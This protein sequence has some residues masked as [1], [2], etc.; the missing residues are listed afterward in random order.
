MVYQRGRSAVLKVFQGAKFVGNSVELRRLRGVVGQSG[1][2]R[3]GSGCGAGWK[4]KRVEKGEKGEKGENSD[5]TLGCECGN[6]TSRAASIWLDEMTVS[7][8]Y[9]S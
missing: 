2:H 9:S 3:G 6:V 5:L 7:L 1:A 8:V 4:V